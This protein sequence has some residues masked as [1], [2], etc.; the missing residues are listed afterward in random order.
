MTLPK[1]VLIN[2]KQN[3]EKLLDY[4]VQNITKTIKIGDKSFTLKNISITTY[5][6]IIVIINQLLVKDV[7]LKH[8]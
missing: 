6:L 4:L 3:L 8:I 7:Y 1:L 2:Q 5:F